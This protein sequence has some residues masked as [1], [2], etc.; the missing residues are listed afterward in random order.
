MT[1][2]NSAVSTWAGDEVAKFASTSGDALTEHRGSLQRRAAKAFA[3][4]AP[5]SLTGCLISIESCIQRE[6]GERLPRLCHL[7]LLQQRNA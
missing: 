6:R 3:L 5:R 1:R 2:T 7:R 4:F